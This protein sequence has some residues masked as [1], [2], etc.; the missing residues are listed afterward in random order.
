[1]LDTNIDETD[2]SDAALPDSEAA[3]QTSEEEKSARSPS[4]VS[5]GEVAA[6][7]TASSSLTNQTDCSNKIPLQ[8]CA[9]VM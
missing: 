4:S 7:N 9:M 5:D 8:H 3:S 1:M 6:P 2:S